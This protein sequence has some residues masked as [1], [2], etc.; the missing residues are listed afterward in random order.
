L[1]KT[2]S[3]LLAL[4]LF[5]LANA[6]LLD[7]GSYSIEHPLITATYFTAVEMESARLISLDPD[8]PE[9]EYGLSQDPIEGYV[10]RYQFTTELD[11]EQHPL[12]PG[13]YE[14]TLRA[15]DRNG[16][17]TLDIAT[18]EITGTSIELIE[19]PHGISED[20]PYDLIFLTLEDHKPKNMTCDYSLGS[21]DV[22]M[23]PVPHTGN[24][25]HIIFDLNFRGH[26]Y[27]I[28]EEASGRKTAR[29]FLV[30][31]DDSEPEINA[32]AT[33][34]LVRDTRDKSTYIVITTD[35]NTVCTLDEEPFAGADPDDS[36]S[37]DTRHAAK[38]YYNEITD[39]HEHTYNHIIECVNEAGLDATFI[40]PVT[41]HLALEPFID[42][43]HPPQFTNESSFTMRVLPTFYAEACAVNGKQMTKDTTYF[44]AGFSSVTDGAHDFK[45]FCTG[46]DDV[47]RNY[48]V[49]VDTTPPVMESLDIIGIPCEN[50]VEFSYSTTNKN[51]TLSYTWTIFD[52]DDEEVED[53]TTTR[54]TDSTALLD[55]D[56]TLTVYADD[57]AGNIGRPLTLEF[58]VLDRDDP[59]CD[60]DACID[61]DD[62]N[63]DE[64][65]FDNYCEDV[66]E[67][68]ED[69]E[70]A[71]DET[72]YRGVCEDL[73]IEPRDPCTSDADCATGE[74]C[75]NYLC[76]DPGTDN[77]CTFNSDCPTG[78]ICVQN[79]CETS[80]ITCIFDSDCGTDKV[81]VAG[82]CSAKSVG[83]PPTK[84]NP[85]L[86][87]AS[88]IE[89]NLGEECR[90]GLCVPERD[91]STRTPI[92]TQKPKGFPWLAVILII[93]GVLVMGGSGFFLYEQHLEKGMP[94]SK[95]GS[96]GPPP[97]MGPGPD[98]AA[99]KAKQRMMREQ[100]ALA[101]QRQ[102][103]AK[104]QRKSRT[105][106][107]HKTFEKFEKK[108]KED[109][110]FDKL[111]KIGK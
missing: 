97:S 60:E 110:V 26:V 31:W 95:P 8:N 39:D 103:K 10:D 76:I 37:Y 87:C 4:L 88:D 68:E 23:Q 90:A 28:C 55:G 48:T 105:E 22:G 106:E 18:F 99:Q 21:F 58:T 79:V 25:T 12:Y 101:Q 27:L 86:G 51:D 100:A 75:S 11:G 80:T 20:R 65:C 102:E 36:S 9:S 56:Y 108:G 82:Q 16:D 59:L 41:V 30:G 92:D 78:K 3:I 61:D 45:I 64:A 43:L 96:V 57:R 38:H 94:R 73:G 89:C 34:E 91:G 71:E 109:D 17:T 33:P 24:E 98:P 2:T 1:K 63:A 32:V 49:T 13:K 6:V 84:G 53:D 111:E 15:T 69:D 42:V 46:S 85:T 52:E 19:P 62:C 7:L 14:L 104:T 93:L 107:R 5:P 50:L 40:L 47:E 81:C 66:P 44:T 67:C 83:D 29:R 54:T 70:C 74:L 35:D 77:V 72:C